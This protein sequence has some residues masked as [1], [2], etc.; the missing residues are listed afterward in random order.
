MKQI[1]QNKKE[2]YPKTGDWKTKIP[3]VSDKCVGCETCVK[4]CPEATMFM[5]EINGKKRAGV[6]Y[7]FCKGCGV[8][9]EVCPYGAIEMKDIK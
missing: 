7:D 6:K 5:G 3:V 1:I 2:S 9:A 4:H 8:C